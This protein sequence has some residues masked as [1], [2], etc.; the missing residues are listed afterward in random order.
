[1]QMDISDSQKNTM[2]S[3]ITSSKTPETV[4]SLSNLLTLPQYQSYFALNK[5][6]TFIIE[7]ISRADYV[8]ASSMGIDTDTF[9]NYANDVSAITADYDANG[10]TIPNSKRNKIFNYINNLPDL[11]I[12][13][14][15]YLLRTAG[16]SAKQYK[17]V[18]YNYIN[19]L[20]I[21]ATEKNEIW[22][23]MYGK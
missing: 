5:K 23:I 12:A 9:L 17:G 21:T 20:P 2:L 19:S 15:A 13:Q 18:V 8:I 22:Q 14:K 6:D 16:Y 3:L 10:N 4:D 1:M 11:N 7:N